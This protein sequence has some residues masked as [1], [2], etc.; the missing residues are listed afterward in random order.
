MAALAPSSLARFDRQRFPT[1]A[2]YLDRLPH[3]LDSYPECQAKCSLLMSAL[4]DF[5]LEQ[6]LPGLP[7]SLA[8]LV[9]HPPP[10]VEWIPQVQFRA[11]LRA[12]CDE[13]FK[14]PADFVAWSYGAQQRMLG[15]PL[16]R[17]LFALIGPERLL[18]NVQARWAHF[19][20]NLILEV[21]A[22]GQSVD[23]RFRFP[24]HM[25][26]RLDL[27]ATLLGLRA[28]LELAGAHE[29]TTQVIS[30]SS[31]EALGRLTWR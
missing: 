22:A 18:R 25:Y 23:G 13:H 31:T 26:D 4:D 3:G 27:E 8:D 30:V 11:V 15:G 1:L 10:R 2:A 6:A 9:Q 17:I 20:R 21:Q 24:A 16:Y 7:G 29:V 28:A 12:I 19:H 5:S 14:T